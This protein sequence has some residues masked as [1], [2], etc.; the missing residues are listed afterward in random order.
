MILHSVTPIEYLQ[1]QPELPQ[2]QYLSAGGQCVLQGYQ[3]TQGFVVERVLSTNLQD[4]LRPELCPGSIY[5][6]NRP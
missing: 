1:P 4:Y 3:G 5:K 2:M 6:N